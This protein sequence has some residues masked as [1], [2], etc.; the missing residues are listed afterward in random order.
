MSGLGVRWIHGTPDCAL[1][2]DP[3]FQVHAFDKDTYILRQ[4]KCLNFEAPFLYLLFGTER[5]LLL[6]TGAG[7]FPIRAVVQGIV[8][9]LQAIHDRPSLELVV[10]HSHG[11]GDHTS[12]DDQF[13]GRPQT[14]VV[15]PDLAEVQRFFGFRRWPEET[16]SFDLGKRKLTLLAIPGHFED[17]IA[18]YD[19][20]TR[21]VLSGD[22]F[23]PGFLYVSDRPVYRRS[24]ARLARFAASH[25]VQYFLGAHI[26][27]TSTKRLAYRSGTTYQPVEHVLELLP[28]HLA[29][30]HAAIEEMGDDFSRRVFDHFI[31][32][33]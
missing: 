13:R 28:R 26:E 23:Y 4:S 15:P 27:M 5:A 9:Q 2:P 17:H 14:T 11:H 20:K 19:P 21:L 7:P 6:D 31:L 25:P 32:Q 16:A 29:Q 18:V 1:V 33:P 12:G 8:D 30:L 3:P 10:A 22:T 24:I